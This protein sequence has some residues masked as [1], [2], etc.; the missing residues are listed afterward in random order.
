MVKAPLSYLAV[1]PA[2]D[3]LQLPPEWPGITQ[4]FPG[5]PIATNRTIMGD[6]ICDVVSIGDVLRMSRSLVTGV[7]LLLSV[8]CGGAAAPTPEP[9]AT[10]LP[11]P[12]PTPEPTLAPTPTPTPT[13][14]I[15]P[16][17]EPPPEEDERFTSLLDSVFP[18]ISEKMKDVRPVYIA[19]F[20]SEDW[21]APGKDTTVDEVFKLLK[22]ENIVTHEG[23]QQISPALVVDHEPDIIV[24][25]SIASVVENP[26]L[27]GLHM[28]RDTAHIPHHI[29]VM[30]EGYSFYVADPGFRDTVAA[31]AAFAYPD[32]FTFE[33]ESSDDHDEVHG[34]A[35][36]GEAGQEDEGDGHGHS[37]G[38]GDS[39]GH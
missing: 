11:T 23:R 15:Q 8:A 39:H 17:Q 38:A 20:H 34:E 13:P 1:T 27:S 21:Q 7:L 16:T 19:Y 12:T 22:M 28:I 24:A 36:H 4:G 6:K 5:I 35:G 33:L 30:R 3:G 26:D 32:T 25:D 9:T 37:H 31:L 10:P 14:T 29:F 18:E 2:Y